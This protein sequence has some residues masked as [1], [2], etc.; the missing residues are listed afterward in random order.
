MSSSEAGANEKLLQYVER[1]LRTNPLEESAAIIRRR[2]RLLGLEAAPTK[3]TAARPAIDPGVQRQ[4]LLKRVEAIRAGFWT[5]Q[6]GALRESLAQLDAKDFPDVD[7]VVR[8]LSTVAKH[9]DQIPRILGNKAFDADFFK[10][11]KEVLIAAPR[12]SAIVKERALVAFGD[13]KLRRRGTKMIKLVE[14]ELPYFYELESQWLKS[15]VAQRGKPKAPAASQDHFVESSSG[16]FSIPWW[17]YFVI[18]SLIR[19]VIK[20]ASGE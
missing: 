17:G 7:A 13:A 20:L 15:L 4:T 19:V 16:G 3:L 11:F 12:D 8:R 2:S 6:L 1:A 10:I 9:R 14:R 5:M 18:I